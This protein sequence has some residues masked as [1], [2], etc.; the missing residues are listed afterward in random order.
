MVYTTD[1]KSV[2]ARIAGS[3]PAT[4]TNKDCITR[5][6]NFLYVVLFFPRVVSIK[7][8]TYRYNAYGYAAAD[9]GDPS[10]NAPLAQQDRASHF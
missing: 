2:A 6:G 7:N 3:S 5:E 1:L 10:Y 4:P 9:A 8:I